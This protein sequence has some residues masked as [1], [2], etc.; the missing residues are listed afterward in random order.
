MTTSQ[1]V[2]EF[3]VQGTGVFFAACAHE[4]VASDVLVYN[5]ATHSHT[6]EGYV[7]IAIELD[8]H[9]EKSVKVRI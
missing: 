7:H 4:D 8:G 5:P 9:L 6:A 1:F 2:K 3:F